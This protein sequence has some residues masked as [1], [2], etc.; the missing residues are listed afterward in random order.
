MMII[1]SSL[2]PDFRARG[3]ARV[4]RKKQ[5]NW[6]SERLLVVLVVMFTY[7]SFDYLYCTHI[8]PGN[9]YL[10]FVCRP[11]SFQ[12]HVISLAFAVIPITFL[13]VRFSRPSDWAITFL[14]LFSYL[15]TAFMV[16]HRPGDTSAV[17]L[18][19]LLLIALVLLDVTRRLD[20]PSI[21]RRMIQIPTFWPGRR[22]RTVKYTLLMLFIFLVP[23][24]LW[25]GNFRIDLNWATIYD[26]RMDSREISI[27][28]LGYLV[29]IGRSLVPVYSIYFFIKERD[30]KYLIILALTSLAIFSLDG[31]KTA[32]FIPAFLFF[33]SYM[34][35]QGRS[36]SLI[37]LSL[38]IL[39]LAAIIEVT[40]FHSGILSEI[41]V[42]RIIAIPGFLNS[43][44]WDFFSRNAKVLLTDSIGR[45]FIAPIYPTTA[46]F[47]IGAT[48]FGR[49][50]MNANTGI[51]MGGYAHFGVI[52]V[53]LMS[54]LAGLLLRVV[55][56]Y[57]RGE[58]FLL[59]GSLTSAYFGIIWSEQM[60]HTSFLSGGV[61]YLLII[62]IIVTR[63]KHFSRTTH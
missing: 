9:L 5:G 6:I 19:C 14:F 58:Q 50:T 16:R 61:F 63:H 57:A 54:V 30:R 34:L 51:W 21:S 60:L 24:Y 52:G 41:L 2:K 39:V 49:T 47:L 1:D 31:T 7:F 40:L 38:G 13:P 28:F 36:F 11:P 29:S 59:L 32:L 37:Y 48:Y 18:L 35:V 26:R 23:V 4:Y 8:S 45:I 12:Y 27:P 56:R 17:G 44:Y 15:P 62:L 55:D 43:V 3:I 20:T 10:G 22:I 25:A 53:F 33:V 42:R 46:P